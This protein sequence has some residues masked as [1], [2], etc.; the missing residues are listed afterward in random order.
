MEI[1]YYAI[2]QY[3]DDGIC[4]SFPDVPYCLSCAD[5][6]CE[7]ENM[8]KEALEL[9]L[10]GENVKELPVPSQPTAILLGDRQKLKKIAVN[11]EVKNNVLFD[12]NVNCFA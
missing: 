4:I 9:S 6:E 12:P 1:S 11:L 7:A 8:A 3:D 10:H 2:F 5:T